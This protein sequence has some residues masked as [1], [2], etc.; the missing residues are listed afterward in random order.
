MPLKRL[1]GS[2]DS[3]PRIPFR[4]VVAS[5]GPKDDAEEERRTIVLRL[6]LQRTR[7][8][9]S[10][11][12]EVASS[13]AKPGIVIVGLMAIGIECKCPLEG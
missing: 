9:V 5:E 12:L 1:L 6:D 10:G 11:P 13:E 4:L 3:E 2:L 8:K 7:V